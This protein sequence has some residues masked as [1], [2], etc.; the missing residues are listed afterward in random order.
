MTVIIVGI[1]FVHISQDQSCVCDRKNIFNQMA[2]KKKVFYN[3]QKCFIY[4]SF[5]TG[6]FLGF[7][8]AYLQIDAL[9]TKVIDSAATNS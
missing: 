1:W 9:I 6:S 2:I 3:P 8:P 4:F 5:L 7:G